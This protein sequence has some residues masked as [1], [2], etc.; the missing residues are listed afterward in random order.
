MLGDGQSLVPFQGRRCDYPGDSALPTGT[1]FHI[2]QITPGDIAITLEPSGGAQ[3]LPGATYAWSFVVVENSLTNPRFVGVDSDYGSAGPVPT[4]TSV[5]NGLNVTSYNADGTANVTPAGLLGTMINSSGA[6]GQFSFPGIT[7]VSV[8]QTLSGIGATTSIQTLSF[9]VA[10]SSEPISADSPFQV[11]YAANLNIGESYFDLANTGANGASLLGPGFGGASGN[12]CANVYAFDAGEELISC[13][14]CLITP[15]QTV[16]L[17]AN[18]DL[19]VKTLTGVTPTSITVKLLSTLAGGDGTGTS[20][21]NSAATVTSATLAYGLSAWGTTLH[22]MPTASRY[23]T[24]ETPF[25]GSGLS[26]GELASI[27]ARCSSILGN[28]SGFG[29]CNSCRAGALGATKL[30]Q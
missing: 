8:T 10:E 15:D 13:C 26:P 3:F 18:R 28:G 6:V 5:V 24:T 30:T 1:T 25:I 11:K 16:N 20:C 29:I 23:D 7:G 17:G 2:D 27:G 22:A 9:S 19:T 12:I 14:S 21:T 4:L